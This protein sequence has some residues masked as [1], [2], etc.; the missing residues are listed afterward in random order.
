M[1]E[2]RTAEGEFNLFRRFQVEKETVSLR[3]QIGI[4]EHNLRLET[5]RLKAQEE[6]LAYIRKQIDR[7]VIR[8]P[9]MA[10]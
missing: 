8:A 6:E 3:G 7:C 1:H 10:W 4:A 2:L 5:E 9:K